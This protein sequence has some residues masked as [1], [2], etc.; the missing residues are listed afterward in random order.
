[1]EPEYDGWFYINKW[2]GC[3][4]HKL[5][6]VV[7]LSAKDSL[8][9]KSLKDA[10]DLTT[11]YSRNGTLRQELANFT[12]LALINAPENRWYYQWFEISRLIEVREAV[13]LLPAKFH[14]LGDQD[15]ENFEA[16]LNV[17][18]KF[19]CC[20]EKFSQK[21]ALIS[22]IIPRIDEIND[23]LEKQL[24]E[25]ESTIVLSFIQQLQSQM[26]RVLNINEL[27]ADRD[28]AFATMLDPRYKNL[29]ATDVNLLSFRETFSIETVEEENVVE[30][31]VS[32]R[33]SQLLASRN[34]NNAY[35]SAPTPAEIYLS[36]PLLDI[37]ADPIKFWLDQVPS[38]MRNEA[39]KYMTINPSQVD[40]E[41]L[42]SQASRVITDIR[43]RLNSDK[44]EKI[45]IMSQFI[46]NTF[47]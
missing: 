16:F 42:F 6:L 39:I 4:C 31:C 33:R 40:S 32:D 26:E 46:K 34:A 10:R 35:L 47:E 41:R 29:Y 11:M 43:G 7:S 23:F 25:N 24:A 18:E 20:S 30:T 28:Y 2:V 5:H 14:S 21:N 13:Q 15:F 36:S 44:A 37:E 12:D 17:T 3:I 38:K 27:K 45:I 8:L 22:E 1:M 9:K 19:K